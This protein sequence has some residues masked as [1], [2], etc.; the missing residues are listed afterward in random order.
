MV[1]WI[2]CICVLYFTFYHITSSFFNL[3]NSILIYNRH[4]LW[5]FFNDSNYS[6]KT[7]KDLRSL[8]PRFFIR[9][10]LSFLPCSSNAVSDIRL[11]LAKN[12][13]ALLETFN[14]PVGSRAKFLVKAVDLWQVAFATLGAAAPISDKTAFRVLRAAVLSRRPCIIPSMQERICALCFRG[15]TFLP[16]R[17]E[18][19]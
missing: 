9:S 4:F 2:S 15:R 5:N 11:H 10:I 18:V 16:T 17:R 3:S 19:H 8:I 14:Q 12:R 1:I 7:E 6:Y 13:S